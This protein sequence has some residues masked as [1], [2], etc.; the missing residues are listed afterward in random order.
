MPYYT[1]AELKVL[2]PKCGIEVWL[3]AVRAARAAIAKQQMLPPA[4]IAVTVK[5]I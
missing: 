5:V 1:E 4:Q 2:V 3:S